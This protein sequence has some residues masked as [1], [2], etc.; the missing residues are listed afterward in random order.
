MVVK[1]VG[2]LGFLKVCINFLQMLAIANA[3]PLY[4]T[5]QNNK[6]LCLIQALFQR[7]IMVALQAS[8]QR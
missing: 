6:A 7:Q 3:C 5:A 8:E 2:Q 1:V 4:F